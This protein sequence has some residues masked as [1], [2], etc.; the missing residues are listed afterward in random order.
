M[1]SFGQ[2]FQ[3]FAINSVDALVDTNSSSFFAN[4][5]FGSMPRISDAMSK[6]VR[7]AAAE[8]LI[9]SLSSATYIS[10]IASV[11]HVGI[12]TSDDYLLEPV[13]PL[14]R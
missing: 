4:V 14:P 10:V 5:K 3:S 11:Q 12:L 2:G 9:R 13:R 8:S 1:S 6:A 7:I